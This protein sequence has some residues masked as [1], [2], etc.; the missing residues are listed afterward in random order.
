MLAQQVGILTIQSRHDGLAQCEH[1][2]QWGTE[3]E[4]AGYLKLEAGAGTLCPIQHH[5]TA[6][7]CLCLQ[8][9]LTALQAGTADT[10]GMRMD[11]NIT[12]PPS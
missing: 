12:L 1:Q 2:P 5:G 10:V 11:G 6:P 8:R 9:G 3:E 4:E 7:G